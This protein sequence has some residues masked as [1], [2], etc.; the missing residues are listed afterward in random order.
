MS[1]GRTTRVDD[2][3]DRRTWER[4]VTVGDEAEILMLLQESVNQ[5]K[6]SH[7]VRTDGGGDTTVGFL[8]VLMALGRLERSATSA[9]ELGR[10][11]VEV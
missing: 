6:I 11:P 2:L 3:R 4:L 9:L 8:R 7:L 1:F 5:K 10:I